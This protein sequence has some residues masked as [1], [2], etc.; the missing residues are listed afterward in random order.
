VVEEKA[1]LLPISI[2]VSE[3]TGFASMTTIRADLRFLMHPFS[4]EILAMYSVCPLGTLNADD[5]KSVYVVVAEMLMDASSVV[6]PLRRRS[7]VNVQ[8]VLAFATTS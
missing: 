8:R 4:V 3:R 7:A 1:S 2:C 6:L 5:R